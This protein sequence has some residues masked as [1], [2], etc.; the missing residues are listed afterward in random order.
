VVDSVTWN[1]R[2]ANYSWA[3]SETAPHGSHAYIQTLQNNTWWW[4]NSTYQDTWDTAMVSGPLDDPL[5][6]NV[7][8]CN[9]TVCNVAPPGPPD[10][11]TWRRWSDLATWS[12]NKPKA[13]GWRMLEPEQHTQTTYNWLEP[14]RIMP[15]PTLRR[16]QCDHPGNLAAHH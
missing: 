5:T 6:L 2:S 8:P 12:G 15:H 11:G 10:N 9:R 14:L 7:I 13:G 3:P 1:S 4:G 16:C